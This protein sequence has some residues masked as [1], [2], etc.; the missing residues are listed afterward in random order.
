MKPPIWYEK[1]HSDAAT[2]ART[3]R[4]VSL[5]VSRFCWRFW[6]YV[7]LPWRCGL[8]KSLVIARRFFVRRLLLVV[9]TPCK[10]VLRAVASPT[11]ST[12][13][14]VVRCSDS[15]VLHLVRRPMLLVKRG[16]NVVRL[17]VGRI[18]RRIGCRLRRLRELGLVNILALTP[19]LVIRLLQSVISAFRSLVKYSVRLLGRSAKIASVQTA[20]F[21]IS[22]IAAV[23]QQFLMFADRATVRLPT[24]IST[25]R[26]LRSRPERLEADHADGSSSRLINGTFARSLR[27]NAAWMVVTVAGTV[28]LLLMVYLQL[29]SSSSAIEGDLV[30]DA[31]FETLRREN[32]HDARETTADLNKIATG[33]VELNSFGE[34]QQPI[35]ENETP[36]FKREIGSSPIRE[37]AA[38]LTTD[39]AGE[40][41]D[42]P[43]GE[44]GLNQPNVRSPVLEV[45]LVR[46]LP[47][48]KDDDLSDGAG[49]EERFV[50]TS[51]LAETWTSE[52]GADLPFLES[53]PD[54]N[55]FAAGQAS[56]HED[57]GW[58]RFD[59]LRPAR[60]VKNGLSRRHLSPPDLNVASNDSQGQLSDVDTGTGPEELNVSVTHQGPATSVIHQSFNYDIIVRNLGKKTVDR[61]LVEEQV[62]ADHQLVGFSAGGTVLDGTLRWQLRRLKPGQAQTL[63]VQLLPTAAGPVRRVATIRPFARVV[64]L[65]NIGRPQIRLEMTASKHVSIGRRCPIRFKVT[66]E[67]P[68]TINGILLQTDLPA[69][70]TYHV[71]R[72]LEYDFGTLAAGESRE[73]KLTARASTLGTARHAA[74]LLVH[75]SSID[76]AA[77]RIEVVPPKTPVRH[78][79]GTSP[80]LRPCKCLP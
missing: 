74:K 17:A 42:L 21:S 49:F 16:L 50:V 60:T 38:S 47:D 61:V 70:L 33:H 69:E 18:S 27:Q 1:L 29:S 64:A 72:K 23:R 15:I 75:G 6:F 73:A 59:S 57:G 12:A 34:T 68:V 51:A 11:G 67:S 28:G 63:N 58:Q 7:R 77:V 22:S 5:W 19:F 62:S 35:A 54:E 79:P 45:E 55:P 3:T 48:R 40:F 39:A 71:G 13:S 24:R 46:L 25:P 78:F 31:D 36:L 56:P 65:T 43:L 30:R 52:T 8:L 9:G 32:W 20:K 80:L 4:L 41:F 10:S 2:V 44:T 37:D 26:W 53:Q 14:K 66:N 76:E